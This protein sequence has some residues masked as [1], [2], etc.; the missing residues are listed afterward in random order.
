MRV[1]WLSLG[2]ITS[3]AFAQ[4]TVPQ[5]VSPEAADH[6]QD[7]LQSF[8]PTKIDGRILIPTLS[9]DSDEAWSQNLDQSFPM[10]PMTQIAGSINPTRPA[11]AP[12]KVTGFILNR[13]LVERTA[14]EYPPSGIEI[15]QGWNSFLNRPSAN[16]CIDGT[17]L[18]LVG[19]HLSASFASV[20][21]RASYFE[22]ISG[23]AGGSYGP[24]GGSASY[25]KEKTFSNYDVNVVMSTVVDTGGEFVGPGEQKSVR[26]SDE[27]VKLLTGR[28]GTSRFV[29]ACGDS[30]VT[31][32]RRGGRMNA[33]LTISN[34]AKADKERIQAEAKGSFGGFSAGAS[35]RKSVESAA[36]NNNLEISFEQ[37]GGAFNGIPATL[38]EFTTKFNTYE[39]GQNFNPRPYIFYTQN[40]RSLPNWPAGLENRV[41]PV[42]QEYY[43]LSYY[44]FSD[45]ASDYDRAIRDP[46]RYA[47]FLAGGMS[48]IKQHRDIALRTARN[49]DTVLWDCVE[50]FDCSTVALSSWEE[51][52]RKAVLEEVAGIP[53]GN[54]T[55]DQEDAAAT[56]AAS[57]SFS[58]GF[59]GGFLG[60]TGSNNE[61]AEPIVPPAEQPLPN[62][63]DSVVTGSTIL[64]EEQITLSTLVVSHYRLLAGLPLLK[65]GDTTG[66]TAP[67]GEDATIVEA[68]KEW[69]I[70]NRLRPAAQPHC[71]RSANHPLC[72]TDREMAYIVSLL[73]ISAGPLKPVPTPVAPP[74]VTPPP[75]P[76][77]PPV[78]EVKPR[79]MPPRF[80]CPPRLCL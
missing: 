53:A 35:F 65:S 70:A 72:L 58:E 54:L 11:V 44:N 50:N 15:G 74:A 28:D 4:E 56:A 5:A 21:D 13:Q 26:L 16:V 75:P 8:S 77:P 52:F 9:V 63:D 57:L 1:F 31:S 76:P 42:D 36:A 55:E 22:A 39:V 67:E 30:F 61:A 51:D 40:Y 80:Q 24:F 29:Q 6:S 79:P 66:F 2:L 7:V 78:T 45:L 62:L 27:A 48:R 49:L 33:L 23:S 14:R 46:G 19:T 59:F 71:Q 41:S 3:P 68:F 60:I 20:E 12:S 64:E 47:I 34:L 32:Y 69:L 43:V 18:P 73:E 37:I 10:L 17:V 38:D 25:H